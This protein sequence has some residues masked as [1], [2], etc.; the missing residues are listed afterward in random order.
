M[1]E[2]AECAI[3]HCNSG[4]KCIHN[5]KYSHKYN[6]YVYKS[7]IATPEPS[8]Q[9]D[10]IHSEVSGSNDSTLEQVPAIDSELIDLIAAICL[11]VDVHK[12]MTIASLQL[13]C[14]PRG[15]AEPA[16]AYD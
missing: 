11:P 7:L 10:P 5:T 9:S 6:L 16:E 3:K 8:I 4:I 12:C 1:E 13:Q 2:E 15:P 14:D